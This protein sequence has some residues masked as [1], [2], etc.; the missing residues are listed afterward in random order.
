MVLS[1]SGLSFGGDLL[2]LP[3][4]FF[5]LMV[6]LYLLVLILNYVFGS[7]F[8]VGFSSMDYQFQSISQYGSQCNLV[9]A[10]FNLSFIHSGLLGIRLVGPSHLK[11]RF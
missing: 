4:S 11:M 8:L 3:A 10:P 2:I 1:G 6:C 5:F 7:L 9:A